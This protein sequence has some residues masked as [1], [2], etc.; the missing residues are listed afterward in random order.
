MIGYDQTQTGLLYFNILQHYYYYHELPAAAN[1]FCGL[2]AV[3][4]LGIVP[5]LLLREPAIN[6]A[7][8]TG[9]LVFAAHTCFN[10]HFYYVLSFLNASMFIE[11]IR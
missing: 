11:L 7:K 8:K 4:V 3:P 1:Y 6:S 2:P 9:W 10:V 5:V